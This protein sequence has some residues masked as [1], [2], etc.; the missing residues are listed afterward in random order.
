[1]AGCN[2]CSSTTACTSCLTNYT[3]NAS[4][5]CN[6]STGYLV[7]G[8]CT[9]VKGCIQATNLAGVV[10]CQACNP[11]LNYQLSSFNCTC[12]PAH[13]FDSALNCVGRCG[14]SLLASD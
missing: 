9:T 2:T 4:S 8:V 5:L 10:Y 3:L 7:T 12:T 13:Y 6:C 11:A 1:M 14:D